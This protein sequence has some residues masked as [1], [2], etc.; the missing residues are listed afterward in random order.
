MISFAL[1]EEQES[2][3]T[4]M[5]EAAGGKG[6]VA[7]QE[8]ARRDVTKL[9]ID[10]VHRVQDALATLPQHREAYKGAF[11]E[12]MFK[13]VVYRQLAPYLSRE[14]G[15]DLDTAVVEGADAQALAGRYKE[16]KKGPKPKHKNKTIF[17][18]VIPGYQ[19]GGTTIRE[20]MVR[21]GTF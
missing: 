11:S 9:A 15:I 19:M 18:V 8:T 13:D 16:A 6:A 21:L 4:A 3:R 17:S 7:P 2:V 14:F 20:A 1:T 12:L 5:H 10:M